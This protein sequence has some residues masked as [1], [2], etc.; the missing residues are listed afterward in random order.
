MI[1]E[2]EEKQAIPLS[3]PTLADK[4]ETDVM[5]KEFQDLVQRKSLF[6]DLAINLQ[7]QLTIILEEHKKGFEEI[8]GNLEEI[9]KIKSEYHKIK[10]EFEKKNEKLLK[11][12]KED[13]ELQKSVNDLK[14]RFVEVKDEYQTILDVHLKKVQ[15]AWLIIR[16]SLKNLNFILFLS[17]RNN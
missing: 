2:Q 5:E 3:S 8:V 6:D 11:S 9:E 12:K 15:S 17:K 10:E 16:A 13:P 7:T 14:D 1:I 4:D